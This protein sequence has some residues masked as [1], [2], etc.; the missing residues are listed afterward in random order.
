M[1]LARA[2]SRGKVERM[3]GG[4][5]LSWSGLD[6]R[7]FAGA[8]SVCLG[9]VGCGG[10]ADGSDEVIILTPPDVLSDEGRPGEDLPTAGLAGESPELPTSPLVPLGREWQVLVTLEKDP[11]FLAADDTLL[12]WVSTDVRH[13]NYFLKSARL[14]T[15]NVVT[16][17]SGGPG[18]GYLVP[19]GEYVYF[20]EG[21]TGGRIGRVPRTG[22][23][24][25]TIVSS[26]GAQGFALDGDALYWAETGSAIDSGKLYRTSLSDRVTELLADGLIAPKR[27]A[28]HGSFVYIASER[29]VCPGEPGALPAACVGGGVHRVQKSG[30]ATEV[31][32]IG[33]GTSDLVVNDGGMYWFDSAIEQLMFAPPGGAEQKLATVPVSD[34]GPFAFDAGALYWAAES[35]VRRIAF[36][37][38]V[39]IGLGPE[40]SLPTSVAV[41]HGWLYVAEQGRDRIARTPAEP[42][43]DTN[44]R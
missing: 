33:G 38:N 30:G 27:I 35:Q 34:M 24:E 10:R 22:G 25:E 9:L 17:M 7:R 29:R 36:G 40:V 15:R 26:D 11:S 2:H 44:F 43:S 31:V 42:S 12:Y 16:L 3:V 23:T 41:S 1:S 28:L 32:H 18:L 13:R 14:G 19:A 37:D 4:I 8:I 5:S 21:G 6:S 39:L 20:E